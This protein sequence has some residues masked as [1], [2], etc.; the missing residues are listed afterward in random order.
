MTLTL[1][2]FLKPV[3]WRKNIKKKLNSK[4]KNSSNLNNKLSKKKCFMIENYSNSKS[5]NL[6]KSKQLNQNLKINLL[7]RRLSTKNQ[8]KL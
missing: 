5:M 7:S 2:T 4:N 6:N 8:Q 1:K 3:L